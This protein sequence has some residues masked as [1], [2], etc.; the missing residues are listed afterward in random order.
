MLHHDDPPIPLAVGK[1]PSVSP[2]GKKLAYV[3]FFKNFQNL[4]LMLIQT[5][6]PSLFLDDSPTDTRRRALTISFDW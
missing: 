3:T 2:D 4:M 5:R 1:Q 6:K